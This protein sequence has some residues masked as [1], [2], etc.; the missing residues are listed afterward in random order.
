M[1][2]YQPLRSLLFYIS[3]GSSLRLCLWWCREVSLNL[4]FTSSDWLYLCL[5]AGASSTLMYFKGC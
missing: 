2:I 4:C 5:K 3:T 1:F